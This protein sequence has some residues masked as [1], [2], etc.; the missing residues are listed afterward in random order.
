MRSRKKMIIL[1]FGVSNVGKTEVGK[2][3]AFAL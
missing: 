1:I 2:M 3:L